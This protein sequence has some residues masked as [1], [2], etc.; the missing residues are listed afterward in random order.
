MTRRRESGQ[1]L[2]ALVAAAA[3]AL[4]PAVARAGDGAGDQ[5]GGVPALGEYIEE[6]PTATGSTPTSPPKSRWKTVKP[7]R[8]VLT[9]MHS[10]ID[11]ETLRRELPDGLVPA[12][13]MMRLTSG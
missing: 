6:V 12:F 5:L 2:A 11:Y 13:D 8:A 3:V 4:S 10:D 1:V 9:N 7:R